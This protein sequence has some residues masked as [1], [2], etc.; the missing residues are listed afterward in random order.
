ML[1]MC[2]LCL[3]MGIVL[4]GTGGALAM[5]VVAAGGRDLDDG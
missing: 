4:G 2:W 5:G 1:T 3:V